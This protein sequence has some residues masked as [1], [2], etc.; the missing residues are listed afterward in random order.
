MKKVLIIAGFDPSGGAGIV[1]DTKVVRSL[2]EYA[3][4]L[5]TCLTVQTT[6]RVYGA[7]PIDPDFF[8]YQF[9]KLVEDIKPDSVKIGL[10]G[11]EDI[12][13]AVLKNIK[14]YNLKNI[15]CDPVLKS[16]SG[17]EFGK[18]EFVEFLKSE[19]FKVCSVITPNKQEAE[20]IFDLKI[21]NF[22]G[23]I[24]SSIQEK[25]NKMGIKLCVLKG[26]HLDSYLAEDVLITQKSI[27]K[28]ASRR[29]GSTDSI[30]GTGC[31]FSSAFA[32]FLAKGYNMYGA[33]KQTKNFVSNLIHSS[34]KVGKGRLVLNP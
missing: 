30:H 20:A 25:M 29:K 16:T 18:D 8:E 3:A 7:L 5:I 1:L 12:A 13:R 31:A 4:S 6:E 9:G 10:L 14:R 28:V 23:D 27:Y 32:T 15:V 17:F 34:I 33:L 24:L 21:E 19:F 11:S 2:G 22:E 26:G